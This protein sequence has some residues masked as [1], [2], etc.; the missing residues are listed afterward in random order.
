MWRQELGCYS[1]NCGR[2]KTVSTVF[3]LRSQLFLHTGFRVKVLIVKI[4]LIIN[5]KAMG[6]WILISDETNI[7]VT[8]HYY[9]VRL[10]YN[11]PSICIRI[12]DRHFSNTWLGCC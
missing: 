4:T 6:I 2:T 7:F 3:T 5:L 8:G 9:S 10:G 1:T 11:V 12:S